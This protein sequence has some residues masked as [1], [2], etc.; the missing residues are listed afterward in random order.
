[1]SAANGKSCFLCKDVKDGAMVTAPLR[2]PL[3]DAAK[4][5]NVLTGR[6]PTV[7]APRRKNLA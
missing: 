5:S 1:M 4:A 7:V 2:A 3:V 6:G